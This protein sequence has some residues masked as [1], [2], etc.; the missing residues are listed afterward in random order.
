[1][2]SAQN[3]LTFSYDPKTGNQI[4]RELCLGCP[5]TGKPAKTV[6]EIEALTDADMEKFSPED[7][8]SY[9]PNPV[10][11]ELYLKWELTKGNSVSSIQVFS[12]TGQ[13]LKN[14]Q[15]NER[16]NNINI[17][18]QDFSSGFYLIQLNYTTGE[19]KTIKII[20]K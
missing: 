4:V 7:V 8:I 5:S 11:E 19:P 2:C 20:K 12:V 6:K 10:K 15:E 3:K 13:M 9:Y 16:T 1:M 17:P 14:Y 18:F